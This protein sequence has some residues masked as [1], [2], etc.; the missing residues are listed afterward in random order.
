MNTELIN[1]LS[2][3]AIITALIGAVLTDFREHRIPNSLCLCLISFGFIFQV[4]LTGWSGIAMGLSG[5]IAGLLLFLPFYLLKGMGAGDVKMLAAIGVALGPLYIL[6][7]AGYTLIAGGIMGLIWWLANRFFRLGDAKETVA[8]IIYQAKQYF[9]SVW[10]FLRTRQRLSVP[11]PGELQ[12]EYS[13]RFPYA[14][15][16]SCGTMVVIYHFNAADFFHLRALFQTHWING[17]AL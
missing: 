14:L 1:E 7:A 15:A 8:Q 2:L 13:T 17:G 10:F 5:L 6:L 3:A 4:S 9:F 11:E 16:I 12:T